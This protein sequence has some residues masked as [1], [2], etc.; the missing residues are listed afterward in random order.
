MQDLLHDIVAERGVLGRERIDR[1][2]D[3]RE[4]RPPDV[5]LGVLAHREHRGV[6]AIDVL[7]EELPHVGVR[8]RHVDVASP[9][10]RAVSRARGLLARDD[11]RRLGIVHEH[12]VVVVRDLL[13][14]CPH[15]VEVDRRHLL[16]PR[17][18]GPLHPVVAELRHGEVLVRALE[19]LPGGVD[20]EVL[21][22]AEVREQQ[23][24]HSASERGAVEVQDSR[25]GERLRQ[26]AQ[27]VH[28]FVTG[29]LP[30]V[31]EPDRL[32]GDRREHGGSVPSDR[33]ITGRRVPPD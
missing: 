13:G 25:A 21:E 20:A 18:V 28:R 30:V 19:N 3:E 4:R 17:H 11:R 29:R 6:V 31:L 10:P 22:D 24:G 9:D 2:G 33:E 5:R 15:A 14:V 16:G 32:D 27:P 1:R 8:L 12:H 26:L 7:G 23:L